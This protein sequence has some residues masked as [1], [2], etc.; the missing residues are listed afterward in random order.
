MILFAQYADDDRYIRMA[1]PNLLANSN[2]QMQMD[3]F[4]TSPLLTIILNAKYIKMVKF[5][6]CSKY[7][8]G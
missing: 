1:N 5:S 8:K 2:Y 7:N 3:F 4:G 6:K